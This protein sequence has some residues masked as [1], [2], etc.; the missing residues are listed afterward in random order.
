MPEG[1]VFDTTRLFRSSAGLSAAKDIRCG[2][3][4]SLQGG[5]ALGADRAYFALATYKA[6]VDAAQ[7]AASKW[8][9]PEQVAQAMPGLE[10]ES[11]AARAASARTRLLN[12]SSIKA[13]HQHNK[14]D[15]PT[16][17]S[18]DTFQAEQ[19][20]KP[21]GATSGSGSRARRC[22]SDA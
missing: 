19:L 22:R 11:L 3:H 15:F 12:R 20:Q 18:I 1:V 16:L 8:P 13:V 10:V 4:G 14:Y 5:A 2:L 9:T 6:G 17:A 21:P 7:K